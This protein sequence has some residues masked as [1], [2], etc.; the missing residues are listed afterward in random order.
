MK[1]YTG[2]RLNFGVAAEM[3]KAEGIPVEVVIVADDVAL[4]HTQERSAARG[5]A[6]TIFVH[7]IAGAA[8]AEGRSLLEVAQIARET[9]AA[10]GT[11]GVSLSAG[12]VPAVG[13]PSFILG[14]TEIEVGLGIHGE[15]GVE[16]AHLQSADALSDRITDEIC[17]VQQL[18][19]GDHVEFVDYI[20]HEI[21]R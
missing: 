1:N 21:T 5:I 17:S 8:A 20:V 16:R 4:A 12:T 6:G 10:V 13:R 14:P 19:E 15:P 11:M 3:A 18:Q 2:D 9:A 7:K